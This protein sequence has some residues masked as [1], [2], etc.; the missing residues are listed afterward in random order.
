MRLGAPKAITA[1][2]HKLARIVYNVTRF[3]MAYAKKSEAEYAAGQR[4]RLEK[5]LH[6]RARELGYELAKAGG[7]VAT[8][9]AP[10]V[11]LN[12]WP[13]G[14]VLFDNP[15]G[16]AALESSA[17]RGRGYEPR[18]GGEGRS[19][20]LRRGRPPTLKRQPSEPVEVPGAASCLRAATAARM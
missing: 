3:G 12:A 6:R 17:G 4:R 8:R 2:A 16:L 11:P 20:R 10:D 18:G 1:A 7:E 14:A 13:P 9:P 15:T 5:S 19:R